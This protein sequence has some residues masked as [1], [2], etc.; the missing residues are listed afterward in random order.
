MLS[1]VKKIGNSAGVIIPKPLL[2]QLGAQAGD[3]VELRI[4]DDRIVIERVAV[5]VRAGWANDAMRLATAVDDDLVWPELA[6]DED[7]K[8]T[9]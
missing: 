1:T 6:N 4:E 2:A 7:E 9:W 3:R 8:L 5:P